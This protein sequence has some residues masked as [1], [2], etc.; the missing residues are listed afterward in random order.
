M[1]ITLRIENDNIATINDKFY[2]EY[3]SDVVIPISQSPIYHLDINTVAREHARIVE[4]S[5]TEYLPDMNFVHYGEY[6]YD[7]FNIINTITNGGNVITIAHNGNVTFLCYT[8]SRGRFIET[9]ERLHINDISKV[10]QYHYVT[11]GPKDMYP[12]EDAY[13]FTVRQHENGNDEPLHYWLN[14]ATPLIEEHYGVSGINQTMRHLISYS[15]DKVEGFDISS[16]DPNKHLHVGKA[17]CGEV[18]YIIS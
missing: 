3:K 8:G 7:S 17:S 18:A 15:L 1:K 11:S 2:H 13:A 16:I 6:D 5:K 12:W 4:Y 10:K 14:K 9:I